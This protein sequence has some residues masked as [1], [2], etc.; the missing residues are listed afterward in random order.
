MYQVNF[1]NVD[2]EGELLE[3]QAK[4]SF[5]VLF[6]LH[7]YLSIDHVIDNRFKVFTNCQSSHTHSQF[8]LSKS[9]GLFVSMFE[10]VCVILL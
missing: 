5:T 4:A 3:H 10:L 8:K 9:A 2:S 7:L 6:V 1:L